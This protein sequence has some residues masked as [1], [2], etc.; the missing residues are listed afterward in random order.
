ML[1]ICVR[2]LQA[3]VGNIAQCGGLP[4]PILKPI[5]ERAAPPT[6]MLIEDYNPYLQE[7]T[8]ELWARFVSNY[9][10]RAMEA[11]RLGIYNVQGDQGA[12]F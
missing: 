9:L 6:L 5:L 11:E 3:N 10:S 4:Y 7:D 12:C 1:E 8:G 2:T